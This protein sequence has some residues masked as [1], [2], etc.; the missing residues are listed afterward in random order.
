MVTRSR[1]Q[2]VILVASLL[3]AAMSLVQ[4]Y[5]R[6]VR[7]EDTPWA[8]PA[9]IALCILIIVVTVVVRMRP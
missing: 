8:S 7:D 6:R 1:V 5:N 3:L 9:A 4:L 2:A